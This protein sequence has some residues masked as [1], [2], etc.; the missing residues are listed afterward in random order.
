MGKEC[1]NFASDI[2]TYIGALLESTNIQNIAKVGDFP[3]NGVAVYNKMLDV[4][5]K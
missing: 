1:K 3:D 4:R 2:S 5:K